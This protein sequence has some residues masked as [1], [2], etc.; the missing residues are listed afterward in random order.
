MEDAIAFG[1]LK[2]AAI[3]AGLYFLSVGVFAVLSF[4]SRHFRTT[5]LLSAIAAAGA[6][7]VIAEPFGAINPDYYVLV[8]LA[9]VLGLEALWDRTL[10]ARRYRKLRSTPPWRPRP[11]QS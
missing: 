3:L 9:A 7:T 8:P 11:P 6:W 5:A 10:E 2:A 1:I 4:I